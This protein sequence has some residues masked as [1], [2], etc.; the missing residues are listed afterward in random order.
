MTTAAFQIP[1]WVEYVRA[2]GTPVIA[3][4]AAV[5]AGVIAYRQSVTA[6]NKL[7]LD[8]FDKRMEIYSLALEVLNSIRSHEVADYTYVA[9]LEQKLY[10]A[11]WLFNRDIELYFKQL[12][13]M[14]IK[15]LEKRPPPKP[16]MSEEDF[17][18]L[19][20]SAD[21]RE[22]FYQMKRRSLDKTVA[23]FLSL[24]H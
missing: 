8:L 11:R 9:K 7:K 23:P 16:D 19:I 24:K 22:D 18:N 20:S 15:E 14:A 3:L 5:I 12:A 10:S 13:L 6:R 17:A 21:K 4:L 1:I 2:L